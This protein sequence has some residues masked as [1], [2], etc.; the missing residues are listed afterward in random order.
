[1]HELV[2]HFLLEVPLHLIHSPHLLRHFVFHHCHRPRHFRLDAVPEQAVRGHRHAGWGRRLSLRQWFRNH[3]HAR[4]LK[5]WACL[6]ATHHDHWRFLFRAT[7]PLQ[8]D[9]RYLPGVPPDVLVSPATAAASVPH[10]E[11]DWHLLFRFR[12][13]ILVQLVDGQ[14]SAAPELP[15]LALERSGHSPLQ[16]DDWHL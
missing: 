2:V 6:A 12:L 16:D 7:R 9:D 11:H 14:A 15:W 3:E 5:L 8:L 13:L 10:R 4:L 1:M